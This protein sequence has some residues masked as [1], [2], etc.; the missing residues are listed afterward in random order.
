MADKPTKPSAKP[1]EGSKLFH[2]D[3]YKETMYMLLGLALL[4]A[5]VQR[6]YVFFTNAWLGAD[7]LLSRLLAWFI[8]FWPTWKIIALLLAVFAIW[9]AFYASRK[10]REIEREEE[11]IFGKVIEDNLL[12]PEVPQAKEENERWKRVL[13]HTHSNNPADW[14]LAIIE[15]DVMLDELLRNL[16]YPGEGVGEMLK[17]VDST[18][19]LTL[20]NAWEAHKVRNRIAHSGSDFEL[21]ERE[22]KRVIS[23]FESVF[24]EFRYI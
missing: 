1:S 6:L 16:G 9:G 23:L 4:G 7:G 13:E 11:K 21:N 19:M 2:N 10:R 17:G 20:D 18:D 14:R 24:R 15:A 3:H 22:T 5:V 12:D 8:R